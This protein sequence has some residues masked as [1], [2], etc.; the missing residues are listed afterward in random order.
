[1]RSGRRI[2]AA[3]RVRRSGRPHQA[4][5][6]R[7]R[8]RSEG[9]ADRLERVVPGRGSGQKERPSS[10]SVLFPAAYQVEGAADLPECEIRP[11]IGYGERSGRMLPL[12]FRGIRKRT[13]LPFIFR[14]RSGKIYSGAG[15]RVSPGERRIDYGRS[16]ENTEH[17]SKRNA[18][19]RV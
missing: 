8:I 9:A 7:P 18:G 15:E 5:C 13:K 16:K 17:E 10:S 12:D 1:M 6:S 3:D 14:H 2:P 4:C 11:R 19:L